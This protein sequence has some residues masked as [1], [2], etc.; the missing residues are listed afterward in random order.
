MLLGQAIRDAATGA[1]RPQV[2]G[3]IPSEVAAINAAI[4]DMKAGRRS[5]GKTAIM[6]DEE[7]SR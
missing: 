2:T 3:I 6:V 1:V 5:L 7:H 4:A